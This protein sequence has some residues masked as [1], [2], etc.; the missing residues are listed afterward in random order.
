MYAQFSIL[1][2]IPKLIHPTAFTVSHI[3]QIRTLEAQLK[4]MQYEKD[5]LILNIF[6]ATVNYTNRESLF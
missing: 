6:V 2:L 5:F 3:I 4:H 1:F